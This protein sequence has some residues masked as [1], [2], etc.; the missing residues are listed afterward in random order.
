MPLPAFRGSAN[1]GWRTK[2]PVQFT[3]RSPGFCYPGRSSSQTRNQAG[4]V[5][6]PLAVDQAG[7]T[8]RNST[9]CSLM[10]GVTPK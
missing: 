8:A 2:D 1:F 6:A 7:A 9:P 10:V 3:P 5:A 4:T